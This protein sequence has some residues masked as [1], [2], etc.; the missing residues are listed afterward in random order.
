VQGLVAA[1]Q[2]VLAGG[3]L[4]VT[5]LP[6]GVGLGAGAETGQMRVLGGGADLAELVPD[7]LRGPGGL[8]R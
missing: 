8:D 3:F 6:G 5:A 4:V 2:F 1:G 7:V